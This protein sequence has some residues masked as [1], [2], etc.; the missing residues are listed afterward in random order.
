LGRYSITPGNV[1]HMRIS[2]EEVFKRTYDEKDEVF[3]ANRTILSSRLRYME[4][5][6]PQ[7]LSFYHKLYNSLIEIDGF[8][9]K[10]YMNERALSAIQANLEAK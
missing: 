2:A 8:K 9:S 5:N 3:G 6:L 10:W 4:N 7:V 1:I